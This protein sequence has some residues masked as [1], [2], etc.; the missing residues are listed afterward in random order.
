MADRV[1]AKLVV[2]RG[3]TNQAFG[4]DIFETT[5]RIERA[6]VVH[7]LPY[8]DG[9]ILEDLG[10]MAR[11]VNIRCA[12]YENTELR[13]TALELAP[14]YSAH[15]R[16]LDAIQKREVVEL[17]HPKYGYMYGKVRNIDVLNDARQEYA[18]INFEFVEELVDR[19][20]IP[21]FDVV[22]AVNAGF[23]KAQLSTLAQIKLDIKNILE[24]NAALQVLDQV[25]DITEG[26]SDQITSVSKTAR[27]YIDG[28]ISVVDT[29]EGLLENIEQPAK[30]ILDT[31][32]YTQDIPGKLLY[33]VAS[34]AERY[35]QLY[36]G[37]QDAPVTYV[38]SFLSGMEAVQNSFSGVASTLGQSVARQVR[39][40]FAC[41]LGAQV[42]DTDQTVRDQLRQLEGQRT[43]DANGNL[44]GNIVYPNIMTVR[45]LELILANLK[46]AAQSAITNSR[47][48]RGLKDEINALQ[49]FINTTKLDRIRIKQVD[50]SDM[51]MHVICK[52]YGLSYQQAERLLKLNIGVKNP[53]FTKGVIDVY[54]G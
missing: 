20:Q 42:L 41:I 51:P 43:F 25:I 10:S 37:V 35:Q 2:T 52:R 15:L 54:T 12:F 34:C 50:V 24:N 17:H 30:S 7:E 45:D 1:V 46:A 8:R 16:F 9:A 26:I 44:I 11:I 47:D 23:G 39:A 18:E 31:I 6:L 14:T 32:E 53:T 49:D 3:L 13:P 38:Q 33:S 36:E 4:L 40:Q 48:N 27:A 21:S 29:V 19:P 22:S 5:D 28:V